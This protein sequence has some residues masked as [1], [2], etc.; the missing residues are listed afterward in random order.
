MVGCKV[1]KINWGMRNDEP[2][3]GMS[4]IKG[5]GCDETPIESLQELYAQ[6]I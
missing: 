5:N 3:F 6:M 2:D 1:V 4:T